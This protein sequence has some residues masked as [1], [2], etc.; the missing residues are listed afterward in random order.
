MDDKPKKEIYSSK[1]KPCDLCGNSEFTWG[2]TIAGKNEPVSP[3]FF[4]EYGLSW[5]D[6]DIPLM[7]R[8][9]NICGSVRLFLIDN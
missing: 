9:C 3:I 1:E 4:R 6:G 2:K 7:A 5:E 8:A